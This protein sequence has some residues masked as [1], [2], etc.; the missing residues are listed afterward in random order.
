MVGFSCS[1]CLL[2]LLLATFETWIPD[3]TLLLEMAAP[4]IGSVT[5][6]AAALRPENLLG[7]LT[8]IFSITL[9]QFKSQILSEQWQIDC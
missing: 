2:R 9:K 6:R 7:V 4:L 8:V 1:G 5:A 3:V